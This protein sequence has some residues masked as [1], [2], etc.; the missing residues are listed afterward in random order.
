MLQAAEQTL[1]MLYA[2]YLPFKQA[3]FINLQRWVWAGDRL[4]TL[5]PLAAVSLD[6][7]KKEGF[8]KASL[9]FTPYDSYKLWE[10][11]RRRGWTD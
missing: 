6:Y 3:R 2:T 9:A 7:L 11:R 10:V 4:R 1:P 5:H 8:D